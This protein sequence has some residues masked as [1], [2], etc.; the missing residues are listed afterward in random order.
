[1]GKDFRKSTP[2]F[3]MKIDVVQMNLFMWDMGLVLMNMLRSK[4]DIVLMNM[5]RL[6]M[7]V[8]LMNMFIGW[9]WG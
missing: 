6:D 3:G 9:I 2:I 5:F 4:I 1:M 8:V 7:G